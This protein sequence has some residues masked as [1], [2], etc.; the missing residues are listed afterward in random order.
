MLLAPCAHLREHQMC[1]WLSS[2]KSHMWIYKSFNF[3]KTSKHTGSYCTYPHKL[4][5]SSYL[6]IL[7]EISSRNTNVILKTCLLFLLKLLTRLC[8]FRWRPV[9]YQMHFTKTGFYLLN[10]GSSYCHN[11][12]VSLMFPTLHFPYII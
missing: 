2:K 12:Q 9:A 4:R 10:V 6:C 11:I 7:F 3:S 5:A 8:I 1:Q